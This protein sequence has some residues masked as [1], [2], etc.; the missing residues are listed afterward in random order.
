MNQ[1]KFGHIITA[2]VLKGEC[3]LEFTYQT[4]GAVSYSQVLHQRGPATYAFGGG[5]RWNVTHAV[6]EVVGERHVVLVRLDLP[7]RLGLVPM[8]QNGDFMGY[9][10]LDQVL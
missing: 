2:I 3:D 1:V 6:R 10:H 4:D 7:G 8:F 5:Y 9:R